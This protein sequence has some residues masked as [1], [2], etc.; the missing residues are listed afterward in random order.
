[1]SLEDAVRSATSLPAQ[2]LGLRDRGLV[3][4][5]FHADLVVLDL[6]KLADKA[7]FFEPHQYSDGV[8]YVFVNGE[9]VVAAGSP[10]AKLPGLVL[11][12]ASP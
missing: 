6:G 8:E 12:P 9:A 10:T 4:E 11:K 7:T 5:G 3:R 2:I 1:L